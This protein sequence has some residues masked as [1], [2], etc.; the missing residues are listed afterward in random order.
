MPALTDLSKEAIADLL[1]EK[2]KSADKK[3]STLLNGIQ[4]AANELDSWDC[5]SEHDDA[6]IDS[7]R[8]MLLHI[9]ADS[10]RRD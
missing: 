5:E 10:E 8:D 4:L 2:I 3:I 1:I 6:F 7:V 9:I